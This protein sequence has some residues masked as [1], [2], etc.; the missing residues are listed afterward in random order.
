MWLFSEYL[1]IDKILIK[2]TPELNKT[3]TDR[4]KKPSR[5]D[6]IHKNGDN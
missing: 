3:K 4:E 6:K 2:K 5:L 1:N